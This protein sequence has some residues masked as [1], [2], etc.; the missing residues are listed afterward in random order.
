MTRPSLAPVRTLPGRFD[1]ARFRRLI[2]LVG[3]A[4]V[5][6]LLT[7]LAEDLSSCRHTLANADAPPDWTGIRKATHDLVALSGSCGAADLQS[8]A[9]ATN[10][11]AHRQDWPAI[12]ALRP[13]VN[14]E[15]AALIGLVHLAGPAGDLPW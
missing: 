7:Q 10:E 8:L 2:Q 15:L 14:A 11:A 5:P 3:P 13:S 6:A 1:A 4:M 9:Q 12:A